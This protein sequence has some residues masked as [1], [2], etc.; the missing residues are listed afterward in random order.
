MF[1][2]EIKFIT[3]FS[4]NKIKK[5]GAFFT[6]EQLQS[7]ELH[8]AIIRYINSELEYLVSV[9]RKKL[10]E[11]SA[12]DYSTPKIRGYF[13]SINEEIKKNKSI[14]FEDAKSLVMQAVSF[15]A[16]YLV[17]PKW[18]LTK[19]IYNE[20]QLKSVEEVRLSLNYLYYY[21]Y[22][23]NVLLSF[24]E[25]KKSVNL[26]LV[27]F[28][29]ALN[30]INKELFGA[31]TE[32]LVD[33]ALVS[34]SDFFNIGGAGRKL[35][36]VYVEMF[37]KE[38]DL[39]DQLF[40]LRRSM[41]VDTRKQFEVDEIK[42]II[43]TPTKLGEPETVAD[44]M[45]EEE[46]IEETAEV[47][48]TPEEIINEKP[49]P[50]NEPEDTDPEPEIVK[51][52]NDRVEPDADEEAEPE[53]VSETEPEPADEPDEEPIE[54]PLKHMEESPAEDIS[55]ED[56][57]NIQSDEPESI[58]VDDTSS[59]NEQA[60][61]SQDEISEDDILN[62]L[63]SGE[64]LLEAFDSQLKALEEESKLIVDDDE[65]ISEKGI[66]PGR[67]SATDKDVLPDL[68]SGEEENEDEEDS[69]LAAGTTDA[70]ESP[71][72]KPEI[73]RREKDIFGF[74]SD[75]EINKIVAGVFNE[76]REDFANTMEKISECFT[77]DEATEIL[78]SVFFSYRVSPYTKEAVALTN[79]VSNYFNQA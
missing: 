17:R 74:M 62:E 63:S 40:R 7:I 67:E 71:E 24:I 5:L 47:P 78:K 34:M 58:S 11:K 69:P 60:D 33:N 20:D 23:G 53:P 31:H 19:F 51:E 6:F 3:D 22:L 15:T 42:E 36:P 2:K 75:K 8:P 52:E 46:V 26:S 44:E 32:Q 21:D 55:D 68:F 64:D 65:I 41:P 56:Y 77:Y 50:E 25:K 14:S 54:I 70:E 29:V 79:S 9:D 76:D 48:G 12:F 43:Y 45:P 27:D 16:N 49:V 28:E 4:L 37:L 30:K 39:I 73:P 57:F 61:F 38:K 18:S 35:S 10:L 59:E 66:D 1:E 72:L 13:D